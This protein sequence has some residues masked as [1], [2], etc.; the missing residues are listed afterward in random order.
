MRWLLAAVGAACALAALDAAAVPSFARQTDLDCASCHL[1]WPELTP[2]GRNFKLAGYTWGKRPAE[3]FGIP[4][5]GM[6]QGSWTRLRK[7]DALEDESR[8][9][10]RKLVFQE[11]AVFLA[12]KATDHI[13]G[14]VEVA[15]EG[16]EKKT[17]LDMVDIRY[18][19]EMGEGRHGTVWGLV[20]HNKPGIQDPYNTLA[21]G[22]PFTGS[23]IAVGPN[24]GPIIESLGSPVAGIGAYALWHKAIYAEV[25]AYRTARGVFSWMRAGVERDEAAA[26]QGTNPYWRLALQREWDGKHSAMIGTFGMTVQKYPDP[27][28]PTGPTDRF[29]DVGFDAQYQYIGPTDHRA[30]AQLL[31]MREKQEWRATP[32][33]NATD[34]LRIFRAKA[35]YYYQNRYGVNVAYFSTTGTS[36][37]ALYDNGEPVEGSISGSPNTRGATVELNWLPRR[38]WRFMLQYTAYD[39]FNGARNDYDGFG[40]NARDNNSVMLMGWFMF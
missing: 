24:A 38:D 29:R 18:A 5:A 40:R 26:L 23:E 10:D 33:G 37:A 2:T 1:S 32:A 6:V 16:L 28:D 30:S 36:D 12:G 27:E 8:D 17:E 19:R 20:L 35:T 13:G 7:P 39:R 3:T 14:V 11:A 25:S 22:F 15:Y 4:V 31:Y 21:W 34:T 9:N